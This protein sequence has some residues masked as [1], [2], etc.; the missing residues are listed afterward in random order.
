MKLVK[1]KKLEKNISVVIL[2]NKKYKPE[3]EIFS[4]KECEFIEKSIEKDDVIIINQFSRYVYVVSIDE[5]KLEDIYRSKE[6]MRKEGHNICKHL[7]K[8]QNENVAILNK[9]SDNILLLALIEGLT[10]SNYKFIK[11]LSS[12][13][14]KKQ[15]LKKI[16]IICD[17]TTNKQLQELANL[18]DGVG[19]CKNLVNEP[20]CNLSAVQLS[21]EIKK[22]AP[23]TG[24]KVEVFDKAKIVALK[25]GGL[26]AVNLG[27]IEPPTFTTIE[28]KPENAVNKK[29]IVIVGKGI[30]YDTGGYSLKPTSSMDTMK[31][32]MSGAAATIGA[33]YAIAKSKIPVYVIALIP[34]TD[35]RLDGNAY[36]PGDVIKMHNNSTVEVLNTDAEGRLILADGLSYAKRFDPEIVL[37]IATLTGA[38]SA[39]IGPHATAC[40]GNFPE[41]IE[42]I[43][44]AGMIT[45]ERLVEF[46]LWPEYGEMI[47]SDIADLKNVGGKTAG[48]ITA[49]KF[50]E[51]FTDYSW[52]HLDIAG[53]AFS[54]TAESYKGKGA[55]GYGVR[56]LY[57]FVSNYFT[58]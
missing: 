12:P 1:S 18:S 42:K 49:G 22:L 53:S 2:C 17:K 3:S 15:S 44:K 32:D 23:K 52:I 47:K 58:S 7:N 14:A 10:L 39:A 37:D 55:T 50:L 51:H 6:K 57:E 13:D 19:I 31:A 38:A 56:L 20:V 41:G 21:I 28:W 43:K 27:S 11:Y 25:M 34:A 4:K 24:L 46:P 35:N 9:L 48:M 26:L 33:M 30:V 54:N 8:K 16:D 29:P 36:V 5:L 40:M 45:Y